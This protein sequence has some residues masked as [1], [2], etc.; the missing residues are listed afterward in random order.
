MSSTWRTIISDEAKGLFP[1]C[2]RL[3]LGCLSGLYGQIIRLRNKF[4]DW[5]LLP[6]RGLAVPVVCIGNITAGGTGKTPMVALVCKFFQ[7]KGLKVAVL[8]RG[9]K[10]QHQEDN[11]EMKLL[12][13]VLPNVAMVTDSD[14]IRGGQTAIDD[15]NAQV[16]VMDDGFQHRRLQRNLDIVMIDCL[17]PFGYGAVIPRGLLREP[18]NGLQR[19]GLIVLSRADA[20]SDQRLAEI[21]GDIANICD[22]PVLTSSHKPAALAMADGREVDL[23]E[24]Q[25]KK[26]AMVCGIGNPDGFKSTLLAM[27]ATITTGLIFP[28][29]VPYTKERIA[30]INQ[31]AHD[32]NAD[33]LVTTQK[34]WVKLQEH[35][36]VGKI[37]KL[38]WLKIELALG[39]GDAVKLNE[40]LQT[41]I[42]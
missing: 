24:L 32:T 11:D 25:G 33:L 31:L 8:S 29:H 5:N 4:Y 39:E 10:G 2:M 20:V 15:H 34:D 26:V 41:I 28:D 6:N 42:K 7:D 37:N 40:I 1:D 35:Q 12:R 19:A 21:K 30:M 18:I 17:C 13:A 9:Y 14:R 36:D 38:C 3:L 16:I 22:R 27:G 23:G